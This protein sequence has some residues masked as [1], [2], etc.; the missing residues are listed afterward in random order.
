MSLRHWDYRLSN[1]TAA[2]LYRYCRM[3]MRFEA[4]RT[5]PR[6][7]PPRRIFRVEI[8]R[9]RTHTYTHTHICAM[10]GTGSP[11][12]AYNCIRSGIVF[13]ARDKKLIKSRDTADWPR[14]RI[15]L[16][17]RLS[18]YFSL[19]VSSYLSVSIERTMHVE[20]KNRARARAR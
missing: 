1:T 3:T 9:S 14:A 20:R 13:Q 18:I 15:K 7:S 10:T 16:A 8:Q 2:S 6:L 19:S 5:K 11:R 12:S 17:A 4:E